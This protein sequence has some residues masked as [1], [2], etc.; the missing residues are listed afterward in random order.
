[1]MLCL[2]LRSRSDL[3]YRR[4]LRHFTVAEISEAFAAARGLALPSQL[5]KLLRDQ[6]RDLHAEFVTL[7]PTRPRPIGIQRWSARRVGLLLLMVPV[8][9][10]LAFSF[11]AVLVNNDNT[12]TPLAVHRLDCTQLEPL[13]L[14]AQSVPSASRV[15]CVRALPEGWSFG[16]ANV[17]NGWSKFTLDHDRVGKPA[18]VIRLT[19]TCDTTGAT[20]ATPDQHGTQRYERTEPG[21]AGPP[22]SWHTVFTGGCVTTELRSSS[23]R[24]IADRRGIIR[25]RLHQPRRPRQALEQRSNGRLHLDPDQTD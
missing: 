9:V 19:A 22:T 10:L 4:A 14:E 6:G 23:G 17:R 7:L 3:V 2:A 24:R 20:Q 12:I 5:R 18:L 13:W 8:A 16:A 21:Q 11:R 15:P 1:M 25:R